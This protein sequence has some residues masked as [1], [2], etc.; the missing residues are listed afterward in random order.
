MINI[1]IKT[2]NAAFE[3]ENFG[4]EVARILRKLADR[5]EGG[6]MPRAERDVNGNRVVT[7]EYDY[8]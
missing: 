4:Y 1:N 6:E 7:V 5:F 3:G 8:E 2:G